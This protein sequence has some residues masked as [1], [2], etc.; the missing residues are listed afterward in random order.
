M[1]T[2][3]RTYTIPLRSEVQKAPHKKRAK[4]AITAIK[5]FISR[6]MKTDQV[7][8]GA[9]LNEY[10]WKQGIEN[11]PH[12]VTVV[13]RKEDELA[14]ANLPGK[15]LEP[16]KVEQKQTSQDKGMLES[17]IEK[18][19]GTKEETPEEKPSEKKESAAESKQE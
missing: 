17:Q 16:K 7:G 9:E 13:I 3:E 1:A 6:H 10:V 11:P 4:K 5:D 8:I 12:K 19:K 15:S 2:L 18:I 14:F